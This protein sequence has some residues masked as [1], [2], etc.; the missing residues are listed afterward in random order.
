MRRVVCSM[1]CLVLVSILPMIVSAQNPIEVYVNSEKTGAGSASV[2]HDGAIYVPTAVIS[3]GIG[4]K[5]AYN[6]AD[7]SLAIE[8]DG[9]SIHMK[10]GHG[11]ANVNRE[12]VRIDTPPI[13]QDGRVL[14]PLRFIA[15]QLGC[16]LTWDNLTKS[17]Y[18]FMNKSAPARDSAAAPP[19]KVDPLVMHDDTAQ[20]DGVG[21]FELQEN[22]EPTV[23]QIRMEG[24][25]LIIQLSGNV[26]PVS[27]VQ[28]NPDK[29]VIDLPHS[30]FGL[31]LN[32]KDPVQNGE[33]ASSHPLINQIRY[34]LFS[35]NPN[36]IRVVVD[37]KQAVPYD[38]RSDAQ[39]RQVILTLKYKPFKVVI[40]AGHGG[41]DPGTDQY[42]PIEE[43]WFNLS[44]AGKVNQL[45]A[46]EPSVQ[47]YM[48]RTDDTF[49]ELDD[50]VKL[51]NDLN[52]D[53]FVS[54][55]GNVYENNSSIRGS[56]TYYWNSYSYDLAKVMHEHVLEATGFPDREVRKNK[57]RV[58]ANTSMPAVLLEVGYL[59]NPTDQKYLL[60][61]SFQDR[62]ASGIAEGILEYL[63]AIR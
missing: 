24:D 32:G 35:N 3:E 10:I 49:V 8:Q 58:I 6:E 61:E 31:T 43:K 46:K 38:I 19:N 2:I 16:K 11:E 51:A 59:S 18:I 22:R 34:A 50:R 60:D 36:T 30:V 47:P 54:L 9:V 52:A 44:L 25:R 15:E 63:K 56:E 20:A 55:H 33:V 40:D 13:L 48:T 7:Q 57:L 21:L 62:L 14:A 37:L 39:K 1:L 45:L 26:S 17:A 23:D 29:I 41:K 42:A 28:R 5:I 4:A 27:F 53:L 12:P